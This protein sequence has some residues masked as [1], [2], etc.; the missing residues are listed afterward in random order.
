[1]KLVYD[2]DETANRI[3][4]PRGKPFDG[5]PVLVKLAAGWVEARWEPPHEWRHQE[6]V[7]YDGFCWIVLDDSKDNAE[8]DDVLEWLPL[9]GSIWWLWLVV[10]YITGGVKVFPWR[11][12]GNGMG[13]A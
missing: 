3:V 10:L 6:G 4:L 12:Y 5:K 7:E 1:M 2:Y 8:L 11:Y 13:G 9:P